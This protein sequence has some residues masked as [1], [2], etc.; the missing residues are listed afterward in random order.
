MRRRSVMVACTVSAC[1]AATLGPGLRSAGATAATPPSWQ[2]QD[3]VL[4]QLSGSGP[5][6][7]TGVTVSID[8]A[9]PAMS[10]TLVAPVAADGVT[11]IRGWVRQTAGTPGVMQVRVAD[12][13]GTTAVSAPL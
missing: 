13:A 9:Q 4:S 1:L 10:T 6:G 12:S 5:A 2:A 3:A 8:G 7:S 11:G